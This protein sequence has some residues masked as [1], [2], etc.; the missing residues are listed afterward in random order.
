MKPLGFL[1]NV[2][3]PMYDVFQPTPANSEPYSV[4]PPNVSLVQRNPNTAMDRAL[5]RGYNWHRTDAVPQDVFDRV[6]WYAT[7]GRNSRPPP[8]GPNAAAGQ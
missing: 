2:A 5:S 6:L 4:I 3:T 8:P 1:D 7:H